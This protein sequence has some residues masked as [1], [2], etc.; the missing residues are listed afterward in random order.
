MLWGNMQQEQEH[1]LNSVMISDDWGVY[2]RV[3]EDERIAV[4]VFDEEA[5]GEAVH[6]GY[7]HSCRLTLPIAGFNSESGLPDEESVQQLQEMEDGFIDLLNR[8]QI[9]SRLVGRMTHHGVRELAFQVQ[10]AGEFK[11]LFSGWAEK[12]TPAIKFHSEKGWDF[13]DE[14]LCPDSTYRQQMGDQQVIDRLIEAGSDPEKIHCLEHVFI[15]PTAALKEVEEALELDGF[16]MH[17]KEEETLVMKKESPLD[18][19]EIWAV[20]VGLKELAESNGVEYD[21]WGCFVVK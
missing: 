3:L 18:L 10:D 15:G 19:W 2:I 12:Q 21:G 4:V 13:F 11:A 7:Q 5:A 16:V 8:A 17:S 1:S 6:E 20:T 9:A 14:V